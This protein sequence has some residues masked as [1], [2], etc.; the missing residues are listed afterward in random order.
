MGWESCIDGMSTINL[1]AMILDSFMMCCGFSTHQTLAAK[2][3]L[4]DRSAG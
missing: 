2:S 4:V 3:L 1:Q